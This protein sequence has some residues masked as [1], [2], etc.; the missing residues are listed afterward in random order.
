MAVN[1]SDHQPVLILS[2]L[3]NGTYHFVLTITNRNSQKARDNVTLTVLPNS[4]E[5][6]IL[7]VFVE[8]DP[9]KFTQEDLVGG[10]RGHV[11][12]ATNHVTWSV[13]WVIGSGDLGHKS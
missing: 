12:W 4:N 13:I 9:W 7:Q 3:V 5:R 1:H 8:D 10:A 6:D 2:N 11:S